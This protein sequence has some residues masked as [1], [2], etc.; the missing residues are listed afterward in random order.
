MN[1]AEAKALGLKF[2]DR[3]RIGRGV[4]SGQAKTAADS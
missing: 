4:G 2:P 1:L 3:K